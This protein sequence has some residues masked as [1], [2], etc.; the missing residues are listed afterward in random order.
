LLILQQVERAP[1]R[2]AALAWEGL[3]RPVEAEDAECLER[4]G[5]HAPRKLSERLYRA[6]VIGA[7]ARSRTDN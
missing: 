3:A 2:L 5:L 4:L 1:L 7:L 6:L